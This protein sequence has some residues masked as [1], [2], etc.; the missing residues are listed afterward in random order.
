M[1]FFDITEKTL[2]PRSSCLCVCTY[3]QDVFVSGFPGN[4]THLFD[5]NLALCFFLSRC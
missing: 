3:F 4:N 1:I 5:N 2:M